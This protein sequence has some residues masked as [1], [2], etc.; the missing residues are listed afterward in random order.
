MIWKKN[1][2]NFFFHFIFRWLGN[3]FC[4]DVYLFHPMPWLYMNECWSCVFASFV[5]AKGRVV[6]FWLFITANIFTVLHWVKFSIYSYILHIKIYTSMYIC[7][8]VVDMLLLP[9]QEKTCDLN[10]NMKI[11]VFLNKFS[12]KKEIC[13]GYAIYS[14]ERKKKM[15]HLPSVSYTHIC[16]L[17]Y[18]PDFFLYS[19]KRHVTINIETAD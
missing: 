11:L 2:F 5:L 16:I 17:I 3:W 4:K 18:W 9:P 10:W 14:R 7:V 6:W 13:F 12:I 19:S 15:T 1:L 8:Y